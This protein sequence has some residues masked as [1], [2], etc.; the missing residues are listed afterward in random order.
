MAVLTVRDP[1]VTTSARQ[2]TVDPRIAAAVRAGSS[3]W[4]GPDLATGWHQHPFHQVELALAGTAEVETADGRALLTPGDVFWVPAETP[5][6]ATLRRLR[7]ITV[8]FAPGNGTLDGADRATVTTAAPVLREMLAYAR[9][10]PLDR[11]EDEIGAVAFFAALA[12]VLLDTLEQAPPLWLPSVTDPVVA[13]AM[14]AT[15]G[16]LRSTSAAAVSDQVGVSERTL[17]R[18][19]ES[20]VGMPW[21]DYL[22]R[23]RLLRAMLLLSDP[24]R[25]L[26]G[27]AEEVGFQSPSGFTRAFRSLTGETPAAFRRRVLAV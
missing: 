4:D 26:P 11:P 9:R 7:S 21:Q 14:A 12:V 20:Q 23:A 2:Q 3:P 16:A 24:D 25:P 19:F 13:S 6:S 1:H 8:A 15:L 5:H 22:T 18:R 10:W 27:V 17:R